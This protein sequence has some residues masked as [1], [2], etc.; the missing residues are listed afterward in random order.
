MDVGLVRIA[1]DRGIAIIE[2]DAA[3]ISGF[4]AGA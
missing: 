4:H 3:S 2:D 1:D